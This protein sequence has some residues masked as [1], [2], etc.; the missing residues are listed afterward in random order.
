MK[1]R[2]KRDNKLRMFISEFEMYKT[3]TVLDIQR[4]K[5]LGNSRREVARILEINPRTVRRYW[6]SDPFDLPIIKRNRHSFLEQYGADIRE[7]FDTHK[8]ADVV[9]Q[10][11]SKKF[12]V[13]VALRTLQNFIKP[14]RDE[15]N[16]KR[17]EQ[18]KPLQRIETPPGEFLQIDFGERFV[19]IGGVSTKVHFFIATLAYSRRVF[20]QVSEYEKQDD[21]LLGIEKAFEHF[22]GITRFIVCDNPKAM[23]KKPANRRSRICKFNE[24][25]ANFCV[26]WNVTPIACYP[27]YPQ[28]KGKVE[29]MV[30]YVKNNG[31]AGHRFKTFDD[32][33]LHLQWW[34]TNVSD[35]RVFSHLVPEEEPRLKRRF[36]VELPM[37]RPI[38]KPSFL[39]VREVLRVVDA[40]GCIS[41]DT[42]QYQLDAVYAKLEVRVVVSK[43]LLRVF[44]G[45][46]LI[47][48]FDKTRDVVKPTIFTEVTEYGLPKFGSTDIE[49]FQ[50]PLQRPLTD[51]E[52][53]IGGSW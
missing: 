46:K 18:S 50:N 47:E 28:S 52:T 1:I 11:L 15:L 5:A 3:D 4:L 37:L 38:T 30:Q 34:M 7:L 17:L 19:R 14:Y 26:Y 22:G 44:I 6:D 39:S 49:L 45:D 42:R 43:E 33:Q 12:G 29:R 48:T 24:R 40:T 27:R 9:R 32:L 21:W 31:I 35:E 20:V 51:Y 10:E 23:V 36:E 16:R 41:V 53:Y 8:N 25:F 2:Q 13:S